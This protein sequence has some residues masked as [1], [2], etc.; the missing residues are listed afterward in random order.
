M[1]TMGDSFEM[2]I[3]GLEASIRAYMAE[4]MSRDM[5]IEKVMK[6]TAGTEEVRNGKASD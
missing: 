1:K 5:A 3:N 6:E 4:G 2:L